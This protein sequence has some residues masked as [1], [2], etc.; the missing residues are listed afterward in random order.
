LPDLSGI[1]LFNA[2]TIFSI[3]AII[4]HLMRDQLQRGTP[5][6]NLTD[7]DFYVVVSCP[8]ATL[9]DICRELRDAEEL[10][11]ALLSTEVESRQL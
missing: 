1:Q 9:L 3:S 10:S 2:V 4:L 8:F 7:R 6:P 5:K 11:A